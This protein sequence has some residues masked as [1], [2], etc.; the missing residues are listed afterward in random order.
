MRIA[1]FLVGGVDLWLNNPRRPM[2]ASGTSGMKAAING[3][4][5]VSVLDGWWDEGYNGD[6]GWAIGGR[7]AGGDEA[8]QDASDADELYRLL[9]E[10]IVPRFFERGS[11][12]CRPRGS[13]PC[14]PRSRPR[15]A[16][17]HGPNAASTSIGLSACA[18]R[19]RRGRG[20]H[21]RHS[22][23]ADGDGGGTGAIYHYWYTGP[24]KRRPAS[25]A[26]WPA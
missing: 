7:A 20:A 4:P 6:N 11:D 10:E 9:E 17:Q 5:S 3:I 16:V 22:A 24:A 25:T 13:R 21:D 26:R 8:E 19:Y 1:R 2:E 18:S 15:V 23:V 12:G 14:V